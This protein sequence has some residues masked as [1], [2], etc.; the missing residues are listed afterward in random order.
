MSP[1][2]A[3][4]EIQLSSL[5]RETTHKLITLENPF[6]HPIEIKK[7]M[8]SVESDVLFVSPNSFKIP[9]KSVLFM[10]IIGIWI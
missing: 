2:D 6:P 1:A 9:A 10:A 3:M 4:S 8:I 7:E 5:V